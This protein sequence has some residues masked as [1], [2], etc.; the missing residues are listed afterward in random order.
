MDEDRKITGI[1][2]IDTRYVTKLIRDEGMMSCLIEHRHD[3]IFDI[4]KLLK[5]LENVKKWKV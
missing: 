2:G 4:P 5:I 3:G 1:S